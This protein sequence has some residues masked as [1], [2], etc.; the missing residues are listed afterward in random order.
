MTLPPPLLP[1]LSDEVVWPE[2]EAPIAALGSTWTAPSGRRYRIAA[3]GGRVL[4]SLERPDPS[5]IPSADEIDEDLLVLAE[6][7]QQA[8]PAFAGDALRRSAVAYGWYGRPFK[9]AP[10]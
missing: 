10:G 3:G 9:T 6:A 7:V 2:F 4:I 1:V 5:V 8:V